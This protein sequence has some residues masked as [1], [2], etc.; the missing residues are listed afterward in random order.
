M[1]GLSEVVSS[2]NLIGM[3]LLLVALLAAIISFFWGFASWTLMN[4]HQ[5]GMH[6]FK[7][8]ASVAEV[9][10]ANSTH[11]TGIY[12]LPYPRKAVS[13]A[14][15]AEQKKLDE[16]FQKDITEGPYLYAIVRPGRHET[17]LAKNMGWSF[18]R[19]FLAALVLG[20]MLSQTVL[21][22]PGRLA[23]C[24]GAGVFAVIACTLPQMIWFELPEREIIIGLADSFIEWLLTGVV[25][26]AFLGKE[27]TE[28]DLH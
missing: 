15:P 3:K 5:T 22:F 25:L 6:D 17:S 18:G 10:K 26:S 14:D 23:F 24:A 16:T 4:W 1:S 28:R 19:S 27:P 8:E 13:Y 20:A 9:I 12:T 21:A 2:C 7:D 11:G